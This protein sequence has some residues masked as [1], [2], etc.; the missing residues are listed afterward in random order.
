MILVTVINNL[1]MITKIQ[2]SLLLLNN[3]LFKK[4]YC[5]S[6]LYYFII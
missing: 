4:V 1:N 3:E 6:I 2:T 5:Y